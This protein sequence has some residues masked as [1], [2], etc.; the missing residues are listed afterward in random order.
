MSNLRKL[1]REVIRNKCYQRDHN[2]KAFKHEW[3]KYHAKRVEVQNADGTT[4]SKI[5][6]NTAKKKQRHSDN[7]KL[8]VKQMKAFKDFITNL[9]K[10]AAEKRSE[11]DYK[12]VTE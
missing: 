2:T 6:R 12:P 10:S 5:L 8:L 1:E 7:G 3:D 11:L 4:T 9:R